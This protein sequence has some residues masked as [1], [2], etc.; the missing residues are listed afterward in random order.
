M[1]ETLIGRKPYSTRDKYNVN[2]YC[3]RTVS[4]LWCTGMERCGEG[5][6]CRMR[7]VRKKNNAED[8]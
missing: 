4:V 1:S 5:E 8:L 7:R 3:N 6:S 2:Y